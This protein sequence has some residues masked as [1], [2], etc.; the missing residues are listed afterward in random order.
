M[1]RI[2]ACDFSAASFQRS[3]SK[4]PR[5]ISKEVKTVIGALPLVDESSPPAALHLLPLK[6]VLVESALNPKEKVKVY[7]F[8]SRRAAVAR[9]V[10][11]W[12]TAEQTSPNF[13]KH[14]KM[15][16]LVKVYLH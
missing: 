15:V 12:K 1:N 9:L 6:N 8:I 13:T 16:H 11:H 4:L 2:L 5:E 3:F 14:H 10:S 7:T